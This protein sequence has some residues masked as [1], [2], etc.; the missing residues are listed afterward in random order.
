MEGQT[1]YFENWKAYGPQLKKQI[2]NIRKLKVRFLGFEIWRFFVCFDLPKLGPSTAD[3]YQNS[4]HFE[5]KA[6]ENSGFF[7]RKIQKLSM[8]LF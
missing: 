2:K 7:G 4:A 3:F 5:N 8:R 6:S 1:H